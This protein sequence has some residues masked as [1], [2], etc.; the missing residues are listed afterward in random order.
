M[1]EGRSLPFPPPGQGKLTLLYRAVYKIM[2][3]RSVNSVQRYFAR[4]GYNKMK[5]ELFRVEIDVFPSRES[6]Q[7]FT[8]FFFLSFF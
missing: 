4:G 1:K 5:R 8:P 7:I 3:V 2:P 6:S